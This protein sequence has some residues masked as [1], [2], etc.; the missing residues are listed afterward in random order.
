MRFI[1]LETVLNNLILFNLIFLQRYTRLHSQNLNIAPRYLILKIII[2]T[3]A[4]SATQA[5]ET[6]EFFQI[7]I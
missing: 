2:I 5:S 1:C 7:K 6:L 4:L 3:E